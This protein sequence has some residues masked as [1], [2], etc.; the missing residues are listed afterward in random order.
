MHEGR[1]QTHASKCTRPSPPPAPPR[2]PPPRRHAERRRLTAALRLWRNPP[3]PGRGEAHRWRPAATGRTLGHADEDEVTRCL[4][5]PRGVAGG[6]CALAPHPPPGHSALVGGIVEARGR[7][8][9]V[10]R[11]SARVERVSWRCCWIRGCKAS[12]QAERTQSFFFGAV[13]RLENAWMLALGCGGAQYAASASGWGS[14]PGNGPLPPCACCLG[15]CK[16]SP[17]QQAVPVC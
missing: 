5:L 3:V 6:G 8:P 9:R 4:A 1:G 17:G 10:L 12:G 15:A 13:E 16:L 2:R 7:G 14:G 11:R